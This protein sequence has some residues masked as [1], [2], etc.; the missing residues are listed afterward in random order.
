MASQA[1]TPGSQ[2]NI[3]RAIDL[4]MMDC[5]ARGLRPATLKF[6]AGYLQRLSSATS[7]IDNLSPALVNVMFV[8]MRDAGAHDYNLHAFYRTL[9]AFSNWLYEQELTPFNLLKKLRP[10]KVDRMQKT[11]PSHE[12]IRALLDTCRGRGYRQPA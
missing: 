1:T 5:R 10:P 4:Y 8:E 11:P 9:K 3:S 2:M 6:Y 12:V 7:D